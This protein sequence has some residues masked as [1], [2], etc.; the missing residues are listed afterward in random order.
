VYVCVYVIKSIDIDVDI[1]TY[2][3]H[4]LDDDEF[5][6]EEEEEEEE[7]TQLNLIVTQSQKSHLSQVCISIEICSYLVIFIDTCHEN[8]FLYRGNVRDKFILFYKMIEIIKILTV[9]I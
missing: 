4:V 1:D 9:I 2:I 3:T 6:E 8:L 7:E 5:E